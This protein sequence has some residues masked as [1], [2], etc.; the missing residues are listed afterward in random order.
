M[1][2]PLAAL[3]RSVPVSGADHSIA[4]SIRVNH[5]L[6]IVLAGLF[7][8]LF[9]L[10]ASAQEPGQEDV[11]RVRTDLVTV[12]VVVLDSHGRRVF[13]L[14]AEDFALRVDGR[15]VKLDHFSTG[16][17]HVA[18]AFLLDASGSARDYVSR[19]RDAALALF[20]RFGPGSEV[21]V[22]RFTE[23]ADVAVPFSTEIS[24][25]RLGFDFPA[26]TGHHTAIFDS[27][28]T[29]IQLF[30]QRKSAPTERRII[31]L[32]SDGLDNASFKRA[33]DVIDGARA[34]SISFYIIHFPLFVPNGNHLA[35][36]QP[37][38]GFRDLAEKTGGRYFMVGDAK[39]ALNPIAS[40]DLSAIF[41]SIEDDLASQY[42]L[43]F[44]PDE[45]SRAGG[46]HRV[47]VQLP[48][49]ER[50]KQRVRMLREGYLIGKP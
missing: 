37:T 10:S 11:I 39:S 33:S 15:G 32:T 49:L 46:F 27:A 14:K 45:A 24:K 6:G 9:H 50:K 28:A 40:Y 7:A 3:S 22:L 8:A 41:K 48:I 43:G 38:K 4:H 44:Y 31:I 30:K 29:L 21:A 2:L 16:T 35:A 26:A 42:V 1:L 13:G 23:K 18:L 25:A 20:S 17:D 34:E 5:F 36:R 47:E 12:P 19:Q